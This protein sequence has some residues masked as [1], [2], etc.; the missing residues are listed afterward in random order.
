LSTLRMRQVSPKVVLS[1]GA[2]CWARKCF[3]YLS[4]ATYSPST[5]AVKFL[6]PILWLWVNLNQYSWALLISSSYTSAYG[7][8]QGKHI[9]GLSYVDELTITMQTFILKFT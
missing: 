4:I 1:L 5:A 8:F 7:V 6:D 2:Q 3:V 9:C